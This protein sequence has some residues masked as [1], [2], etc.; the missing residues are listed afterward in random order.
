MFI[1]SSSHAIKR[2][3]YST[4][5]TTKTTAAERILEINLKFTENNKK[6]NNLK[7]KEQKTKKKTW[8]I[9]HGNFSTHPTRRIVQQTHQQQQ[10]LGKSNSRRLSTTHSE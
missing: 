8:K 7:I 4:T 3:S 6:K 1:I 10:R 5:T 2:I 9:K